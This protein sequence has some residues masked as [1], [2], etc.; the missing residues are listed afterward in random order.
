MKAKSRVPKTVDE[1]IADFPSEVQERLEQIREIIF[2]VAPDAVEQ[3]SYRIPAYKTAGKILI[4]FA[5]FREHIGMY[6]ALQ[7]I[8]QLE[9]DVAKYGA[10]KGTLRFPH[11]KPLPAAVVKRLVKY[12][13]QENTA[14]MKK[15][16]QTKAKPKSPARKK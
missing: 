5:A 9:K 4:Y 8:P 1:Y 12:R 2:E 15:V 6:P 10:G 14:Q 11:D 7:G 16:A 3:I 13:A